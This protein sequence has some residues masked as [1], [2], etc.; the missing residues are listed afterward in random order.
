MSLPVYSLP[1][2]SE[3]FSSGVE[4]R[5][6]A[7]VPDVPRL[8]D[9][10]AVAGV[11][12]DSGAEVPGEVTAAELPVDSGGSGSA[13]VG[14]GVPAAVPGAVSGAVSGEESPGTELAG[15]V[16]TGE[17]GFAEQPVSTAAAAIIARIERLFIHTPFQGAFVCN[18]GQAAKRLQAPVK[19]L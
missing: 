13:E 4:V 7:V 5:E 2:G 16:F 1:V 15:A 3:D 10:A 6:G 18:T 19:Y 11:P 9:V 12:V 8:P 17:D 14:S